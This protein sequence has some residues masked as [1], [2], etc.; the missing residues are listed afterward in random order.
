MLRSLQTASELGV[1]VGVAG[2]AVGTYVAIGAQAC[3]KIHT[4]SKTETSNLRV[5][6]FFS[7]VAPDIRSLQ[8]FICLRYLFHEY[9]RIYDCLS[10]LDRILELIGWRYEQ[11]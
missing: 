7:L 8:D 5:F 9:D 6:T 4:S 10:V 3:S 1:P 11:D 2:I